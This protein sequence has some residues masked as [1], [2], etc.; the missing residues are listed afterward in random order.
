MYENGSNFHTVFIY[1]YFIN[2]GSQKI[3]IL[4]LN[5]E[6]SSSYTIFQASIHHLY[7]PDYFIVSV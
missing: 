7:I 4:N 3:C 1:I 2:E 6:L 5:Q